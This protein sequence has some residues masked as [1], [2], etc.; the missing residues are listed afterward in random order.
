MRFTPLHI[1]GRA[2]QVT[3]GSE[4]VTFVIKVPEL[5]LISDDAASMLELGSLRS[6]EFQDVPIMVQ[7]RT[8]MDSGTPGFNVAAY[9]TG[10]TWTD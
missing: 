3:H 2:L 4:H 8:P 9:D 10:Q 1:S 6:P 7:A 5:Q